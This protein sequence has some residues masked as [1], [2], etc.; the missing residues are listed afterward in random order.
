[1][2]ISF[3]VIAENPALARMNDQLCS[4]VC[5]L[6]VGRDSR[7]HRAGR[8]AR[9]N[10]TNRHSCVAY[11]FLNHIPGALFQAQCHKSHGA[12]THILRSEVAKCPT[13]MADSPCVG[14]VLDCLLVSRRGGDCYVSVLAPLR[15][16]RIRG[17]SSPKKH[18]G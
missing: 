12:R 18:A 8:V 3:D 14:S 7:Y 11:S 15:Y 2:C 5:E 1:M 13:H 4:G 16:A 9:F 10:Q 17:M 6:R